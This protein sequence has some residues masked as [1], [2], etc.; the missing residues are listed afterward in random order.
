MLKKFPISKRNGAHFPE[1]KDIN[2]L[3]KLS[4]IKV[5]RASNMQFFFD[6]CQALT[7]LTLQLIENI[8]KNIMTIQSIMLHLRYFKHTKIKF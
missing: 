8:L 6:L 3:K 5:L 7:I 1:K 4:T 2:F